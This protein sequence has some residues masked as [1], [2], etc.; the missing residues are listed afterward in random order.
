MKA[1][2]IQITP[3]GPP[4]TLAP[5]TYLDTK[6]QRRHYILFVVMRGI[7]HWRSTVLVWTFD[8]D[9]LSVSQDPHHS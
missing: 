6:S 3:H 4:P 7:P 1:P 9:P 5:E 2:G 8:I